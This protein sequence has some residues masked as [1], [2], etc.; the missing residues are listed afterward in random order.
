[1][2]L[3]ISVVLTALALLCRQQSATAQGSF[4]VNGGFDTDASS[5]TLTNG[6]YFTG[7]GGNPGGGIVLNPPSSTAPTISQTIN[8]LT[9][10]TFYTVS[11]DYM[12]DLVG[13][14]IITTNSLGVALDGV[15]LFETVAPTNFNWYSFNFEYLATS[16]S[17]LLSL[18]SQL[19]GTGA[20]YLIDNISMYAVPEPDSLCLIGIGGVVGALFTIRHRSRQLEL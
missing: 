5:W 17:A 14:N 16:T 6:A 12:G 11:G 18:S 8:G 13:K 15:F 9:P 19:N 3:K 10:G 7:A 20:S 1:M 2:T 4:V